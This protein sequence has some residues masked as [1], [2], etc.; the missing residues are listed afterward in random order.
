M[1]ASREVLPRTPVATQA[2]RT[3]RASTW[4]PDKINGVPLSPSSEPDRADRARADA[5]SRLAALLEQSAAGDTNAFAALY[6]ETAARSFGL[7]LRVV[8]DRGRAEDITQE[9]YVKVWRTAAR[10]DARKGNCQGWIFTIVHRAAVDHVRSAQAQTVRD[11][12]HHQ[13]SSVPDR[14]DADPTHD[15]AHASLEAARTREALAGLPPAQQ[16]A[17]T[18]AYFEGHTYSEVARLLGVPPGTIKSRIRDGLIRLRASV[19][20]PDGLTPAP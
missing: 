12:R 2:Q 14:V 6:A 20:P 16:Q 17:L 9:A 13:E 1:K 5:S 3:G 8:R 18:L 15:L 19:N 10:F 4:R 11:D 7:A